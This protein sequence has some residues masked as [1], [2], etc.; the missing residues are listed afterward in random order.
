MKNSSKRSNFK[1]NQI[2]EKPLVLLRTAHSKLALQ[3]Q[4][5][6]AICRMT[7]NYLHTTFRS[8]DGHNIQLSQAN[9]RQLKPAL[10]LSNALPMWKA[11]ITRIPTNLQQQRNHPQTAGLRFYSAIG[12][13]TFLVTKVVDIKVE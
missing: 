6:W 12:Y 13:I 1:Y 10:I 8:K 3:S 5:C 4:L 7:G 9:K 2:T 11:S